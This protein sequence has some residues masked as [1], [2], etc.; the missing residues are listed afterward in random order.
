MQVEQRGDDLEVVLHPVVDL[1]HQPG[2][3]HD[4]GL[5][6]G[7]VPG[8]GLGDPVEGLAERADFLR[9]G[10]AASGR[11]RPRSPGL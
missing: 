9:R 1:A 3:A 7:L 11:S 6:L 10:A 2:L 5:Q 8:D 4:R